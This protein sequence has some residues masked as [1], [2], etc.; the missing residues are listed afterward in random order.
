MKWGE[1][2]ALLLLPLSLGVCVYALN[3]FLWRSE[4]IKSRIPGR[5]DDAFGPL[6]LGGFLVVIL[7]MNFVTKL[8]M[9]ARL[10]EDEL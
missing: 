9:I 2:Y 7:S 8:I 6:L 5:W 1:Y 3:T 10:N 4:R